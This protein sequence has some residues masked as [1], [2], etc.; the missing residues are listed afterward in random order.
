[1]TSSDQP[2]HPKALDDTSRS[3]YQPVYTVGQPVVLRP[4]SPLHDRFVD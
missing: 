1:M 4:D 3:V 2:D